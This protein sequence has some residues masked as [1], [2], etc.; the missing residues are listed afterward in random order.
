MASVTF[1]AGIGGDGSTV[2]DDSSATTGLGNGGHRTRF[3]PALAQAV[4]IAANVVANATAAAASAASAVN[5]PGTSATSATSLTIASS[6]TISLTLAQTGK[7]FSV[8]QSIVLA[9]TATP[10]NWMAG[11]I[12]AFTAATGAMTVSRALASGSG[13]ASA[14]TVSLTSPVLADGTVT[15]PKIADSSVT[16]VKLSAG[17]PAWDASG[18]L[19]LGV[20]PSAWGGGRKAIELAGVSQL[21]SSGAILEIGTNW[22]HNG[23]N[24][25]YKATNV[26]SLYS[27]SNGTHIWYKAP[28]GTAGAAISFTPVM[29]LDASGNLG[30]GVTP[31]AWK[32]GNDVIEFSTGSCSSNGATT[33]FSSNWYADSTDTPRYKTSD[34]AFAYAQVATLGHLWLTAPAGTAGAAIVFTYA[35]TLDPSGVLSVP[36]GIAAELHNTASSKIQTLSATVAS[37]ALTITLDPTAI[38]FRSNQPSGTINTITTS[39]AISLTVPSGATLGTVNGVAARLAVLAVKIGGTVALAVV[40]ASAARTI[41]ESITINSTA[42]S[43]AADSATAFYSASGGLNLP[44]R[45][46][47][48]I[49]ITEATA[50]TWASAPTGIYGQGGQMPSIS[51]IQS[52]SSFSSAAGTAVDFVGIPTWARRVTV[53]LESVSTNGASPL[54]IQIGS[55]SFTTTGYTSSVSDNGGATAFTNGFGALKTGNAAYAFTG[56]CV[57]ELSG[58]G[59]TN[60]IETGVVASNNVQTASVGAGLLHLSAALDRVRITTANGTDTF[61]GGVISILWE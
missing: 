39:S 7:N 32:A 6:G 36:G 23:T 2:T 12:T 56:H 10:T 33:R 21:V 1:P 28:S 30:L 60:Y 59:S 13:T 31:S 53:I 38:D 54:L 43:T 57:M 50:G 15:T 34:Q 14:W 48:Y 41:D 45:V 19:G 22:Y 58:A 11:V 4:A 47:G 8:G 26:A 44:F 24:Y 16:P 17:A 20:T 37:N 52:S 61:D 18:N 3:V 49:D 29:T 27:P 9:M 40:N 46:V 5:A 55:G 51:Q 42:I 35:M 25:I